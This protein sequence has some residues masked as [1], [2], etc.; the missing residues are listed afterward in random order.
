MC[1]SSYYV[2]SEASGSCVGFLVNPSVNLICVA[3]FVWIE[4]YAVRQG[5]FI[6]VLMFKH[7]FIH[8]ALQGL[9]L[10]HRKKENGKYQ[11]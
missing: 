2:G 11:G 8:S 1:R 6:D 5:E 7:K 4:V 9:S 3:V 10:K